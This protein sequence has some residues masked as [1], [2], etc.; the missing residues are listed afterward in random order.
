MRNYLV[1][2]HELSLQNQGRPVSTGNLAS[3][4][5]VTPGTATSMMKQLRN[6][7][8]LTYKPYRGVEITAEG[9]RLAT[10]VTKRRDTLKQFLIETLKLGHS[11]A[12]NE[13]ILLEPLASER[14]ISQIEKR[15]N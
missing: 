7:G 3:L 6:A 13:A 8:L 5:N 2:I 10:K 4:L 15:A 11:Q 14:L 9:R 12:H 1:A